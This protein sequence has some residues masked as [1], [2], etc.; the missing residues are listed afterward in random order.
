MVIAME[1]KK[2]DIKEDYVSITFIPLNY[3]DIVMAETIFGNIV[4]EQFGQEIFEP[5][6][7]EKSSFS[8]EEILR[9]ISSSET[10]FFYNDVRGFELTT[11]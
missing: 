8:E 11:K 7:Y 5:F 1:V 4:G 3:D 9:M 10:K 6:P 2:V